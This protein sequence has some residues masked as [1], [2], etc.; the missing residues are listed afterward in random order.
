MTCDLVAVCIDANDPLRLARFWSGLLGWE[1]AEAEVARLVSLGATLVG[2][3]PHEPGR[4]LLI[5]PDGNE[6]GVAPD[7]AATGEPVGS[8]NP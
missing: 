4:Q 1:I 7:A 6:F 3:D 5:D 8:T 2:L